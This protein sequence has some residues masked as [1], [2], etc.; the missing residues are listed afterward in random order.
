VEPIKRLLKALQGQLTG[1]SLSQRMAM[2]LCMVILVGAT[3]WL[4]QWSAEPALVPMLDQAFNPEELAAAQ[5]RLE[6]AGID[7]KIEDNRVWVPPTQR[8]RLIALLKESDALPDDIGTGFDELIEDASPWLP[9]QERSFQR[10]VARGNELSRVVRNFRGV[11]D[12]RVILGAATQAGFRRAGRPITATVTLWLKPSADANKRFLTM[13]ASTVAGATPG[14][15]ITN[16]HVIDA[17]N[18]KAFRVSSESHAGSDE[19]FD[20][21]MHLEQHY[22]EKIREHLASFIPGVIVGV[23]ADLSFDAQRS[24]ARKVDPPVITS[25]RTQETRETN[26]SGAGEPGVVPNVGTA[27]APD[28]S[29]RQSISKTSETEYN[30]TPSEEISVVVKD[31]GALVKMNASVSVPNSYFVSVYQG[32]NGKE[33]EA[34]AE[35]DPIRTREMERI[36]RVVMPLVN[37]EDDR[38]VEV[39]WFYDTPQ[40]VLA[41]AEA[42][43]SPVQAMLGSY[44]KPVGLAGLAVVSLMLMLMMVRKSPPAPRLSPS[45]EELLSQARVPVPPTPGSPGGGNDDKSADNILSMETPPIGSATTTAAVLEGQELDEQTIKVQQMSNQVSRMVKEDP[46]AA[47]LL[48]QRWAEQRR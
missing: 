11:K 15:Q 30:G 21:K 23:F 27:L 14:L 7:F 20:Q 47:A 29:S 42:G 16:V 48:L 5:H 36:R 12:A 35:L 44:G 33:P 17:T 25:E 10:M 28:R 34:D 40:P 8:A 31:K 6:L 13:V 4:F 43:E 2:A 46:A 19:L 18:G 3:V 26:S 22:A 39:A 9:E 1:L 37:A 38:Q 45:E 41:V 32:S 24:E